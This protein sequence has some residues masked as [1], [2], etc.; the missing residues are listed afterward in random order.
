MSCVEY[1][2]NRDGEDL[3]QFNIGMFCDEANKLPL[4]Y[5]SYNGSLT[6]KTNLSYVLANAQSVGIKD[7]KLV[8]DG[9]F[10]SEECFKSLNNACKAFTIGIPISLEISKEMIR[11][12]VSSINKYANKLAGKDIFCV[13]HA[14]SIHKVSGKLMLYFDPQ[15][16]SQLCRELSERIERLS[17][18]LLVLKRYPKKNLGRYSKYFILT[19]HASNSGF[20][21]CVN[22]DEIDKMR[23]IKGFFLLFSTDMEV[24]PEDAL[25]YYRAKDADEKLFDQIKIDMQGGR[26]RTHNECTTG[27]KIFVTFVAL[28][29]RSYILGKLSKYIATNSTSLK[30]IFNKLSNI[31]VVAST[32]GYRFTKAL[33]KQQKDILTLFNAVD[34]ENSLKSCLR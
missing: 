10:I 8:V 16:H 23:Q 27:G 31:L 14:T 17:T 1:G 19:K 22:N 21:F 5:N 6:D 34:I 28:A 32:S 12:Y 9:G 33:T 2:Y 30:K 11:T 20:D 26:V 24:K 4:Y 13:Q 7:V 3:P 15:S 18:E 29:I 25:Y